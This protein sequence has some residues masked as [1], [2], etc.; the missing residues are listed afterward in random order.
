MSKQECEGCEELECVDCCEHSE[1][2]HG[3]CSDC[4]TDI[5]DDLCA[6]AEAAMESFQER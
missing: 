4:G 3:V 2:N 1:T 5:S 6:R